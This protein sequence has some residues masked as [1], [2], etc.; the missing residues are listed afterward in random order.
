MY[1]SLVHILSQR[2]F[3]LCLFLLLQS[4]GSVAGAFEPLYIQRFISA[5]VNISDHST[6]YILEI[7]L[8][9]AILYLASGAAQGLAGYVM[10]SMSSGI[11]KELRIAFFSKISRLPISY[12]RTVNQGE[13]VSKFNVDWAIPNG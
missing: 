1:R 12:F 9:L 4:L 8:V 13:F 6:R 10:S 11:L 3:I 2:R 7:F 5:V